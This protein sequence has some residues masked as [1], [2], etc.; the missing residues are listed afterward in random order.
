[1]S[2]RV[3][4]AVLIVMVLLTA[5]P[6]R[7][8]ARPVRVRGDA[9]LRAQAQFI[10]DREVL[11]LRGRLSDDRRDPIEGATIELQ[12]KSGLEL[13]DTGSCRSPR[14]R[15]YGAPDGLKVLT[16][17]GGEFCLRWREA[18]DDGTL[19]LRFAGDEYHGAAELE[20]GFDRARAQKLATVL[21]FDPRPLVL[22]LDKDQ[23][24]VS[25]IMDLAQRTAHAPRGGHR[26]RLFDERS[27][28]EPLAEAETSGDGKV[29]FTIPTDALAG[30]GRGQLVLKYLGD[31]ALAA[32]EDEQPITRR[33]SVRMSLVEAV[34]PTDPGDTAVVP[35]SLV[36]ARGTV[37]SGVVEGL[38]NGI[39]VGTGPVV[40]GQAR[41]TVALDVEHRGPT[42]LSVRYLPSSPFY[43]PGPMLEVT[44]PVAPPSILLRVVLAVLVVAAGVW[45]TVSWR[46][47]KKL[48]TL[49][50]GRPMLT[51]GVH[52]VKSRQGENAWKG[53]VVDAHDGHPLAGVTV[54]VRAPSLDD[55]GI[56]V[57]TRT[58]ER[59]LFAFELASRPEGGEI[60]AKSRSHAEERKALPS[61]G[62][63]RIALITRRRAIQRRLV[64]W[65]RVRGRPYDHD[66]DPTPGHVRDAAILQ[67]REEVER[68]ARAVEHAAFGPG[69]VDEAAENDIQELEPGPR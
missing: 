25:G 54:L 47:S 65:A 46:R 36:A 30:P 22:D 55:E 51:P 6:Q 29:R 41:L 57:Q 42:T 64:N 9:T 5:W 52:V 59:G 49:G 26:I 2:K 10:G 48:P 34:P 12:T 20:V 67:N 35:L 61:G 16:E 53:T 27:D 38:V 15:V 32:S 13:A 63:L 1:M 39:P 24:V 4:A 69:E 58:D 60:V 7:A 28:K 3:R 19:S 18:P 17:V 66:P 43:K 33:A 23:V 44:V 8:D 14:S 68:W 37:D 50:K 45:V 11:E 31:Q 56:L 62:T 40:D 21:R